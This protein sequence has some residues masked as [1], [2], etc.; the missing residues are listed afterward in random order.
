MPP[1]APPRLANHGQERAL[2]WKRPTPLVGDP[3]S[4][5]QRREDP[6]AWAMAPS[7]RDAFYRLVAARRDV[8][9]FRPE[10]VAPDILARVLGAAHAAPSVGHSQPWRFIVVTDPAARDRAAWM[11]DEQRQRQAAQMAPE[12]ARRLLDL[13]LEGIREA[14][15]GLVV[16]C[17]RRTPAAGVLGRSTFA[18]ADLWSCACAIENLWLAARSEGL[19]VGWVTLFQPS[20]LAD[21]VGL[22]EGV[23][24]L[25]W[26]C[27]GWPDERLPLPGLERSGWSR[28]Q[29]V[30]EVVLRDRWPG[31]GPL[32]PASHLRAPDQDRVVA[33]RDVA[34]DLLTPPGSLGVL[35]RVVDRLMALGIGEMSGRLVLAA[36]RHRVVDLGVSAF[37]GSVTDEVVAA[38]RAG[39]AV[40]AV[41]A[42]AAGLTVEVVDAGSSEGNMRDAD[43]L[44]PSRVHA[45]VAEGRRLGSSGD[46]KVVALGEVGV[47]NTTPAAALTAALLGVG[48]EEVVGLGASSDWATVER[49]RAVVTG[50]LD[51]ARRLY[52]ERLVHPWIALAA[53]G[54]PEFAVLAGA[55]LGAAEAGRAVVLDGLATSVSALAAVMVEPAASAHLV[56]GQRSREVAH[57]MVLARLGLEP[58]LDLRLRAGEGAGAA[59]ACQLIGTAL[60]VRRRGAKTA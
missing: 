5:R 1:A 14:P 54:G 11:A 44:S 12:S 3:T 19:G 46:G 7:D 50:A 21:L 53:V 17:D 57:P 59:L 26:L 23:V 58:L 6:Q 25:G 39:E 41:A 34:D 9:R 28:R 49:K 31:N 38:A 42:T 22:P 48:P 52:G 27:V 36:G 10:P 8:R 56:A 29:P 13:Q 60:E 18:D 24:S 16:A 43:A 32:P 4:A 37:D 35:D 15:L 45:L 30:E 47:A 33:A 55:V 51:R 20:D 2:T 40:G